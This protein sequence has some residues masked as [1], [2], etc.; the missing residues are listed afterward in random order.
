MAGGGARARR[1]CHAVLEHLGYLQLDS[2]AVTGAR[3]H[4][5]V[6]ASRLDG[7]D[8][9]VAETLL[10]PGEPVFEYWG[11]EASWLPL[12]LYPA[13]GFRRREY[14]RHPW[15][16]DFI[17]AHRPLAD[18]MLDRIGR[19]G[20]LRSADLDDAAL[21][22]RLRGGWGAD[23]ALW[24]N[25]HSTR[26]LEALWSAG[27]LAVRE[28]RGFQRTFDLTERVIPED[29]RARRIDDDEAIAV[30]LLKAL[31]GL[32]FATTGTLAATWRLRNR[33]DQIQRALA[34]LEE[35]GEVVPAVAALEGRDVRGWIR[36]S[37]LDR[38][39]RLRA[40]RPRRDHGVALSPFDPLLWDRGRTRALFDF[41]LVVEIYKPPA[42]RRFGYYCLPVLAGDA[43]IGRVDLKADRKAGRLDV[44]SVHHEAT[45]PSA[46]DREA[47]R[48]ALTRFATAVGLALRTARDGA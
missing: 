38:L 2:I 37:D 25:K 29:V 5:I 31:D 33:R 19:D 15:W 44:L 40:M 41:D 46:R 12:A 32:G 14:R 24:S 18:W 10:A 9:G 26:M 20:P 8:A 22:P 11:H 17:G 21:P 39:D 7:L 16:G 35:R 45:M 43:L 48:V 34:H 4:G 30:L 1:A 28:R 3:T 47:T 6:L 13:L 42:E 27:S 36:A 23:D